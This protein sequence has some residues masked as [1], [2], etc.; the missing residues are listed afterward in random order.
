MR[1]QAMMKGLGFP[2]VMLALLCLLAGA[3]AAVGYRMFLYPHGRREGGTSLPGMYGALL[4]YAQEHNGWFP[5][6]TQDPYQAL[7]L[8]YPEYCPSGRELA[9][10]SGS[11]AKTA[12]ALSSGTPLGS[13]LSTWV[14]VSGLRSDDPGALAILWD[15]KPG[16]YQ[17]GR[18]NSFGGR[19]VLFVSGNISNVPAMDWDRFERKQ[20]ELRIGLQSKR[21]TLSDERLINPQ[22]D[23]Q[24]K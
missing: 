1:S 9:G 11:P 17:D 19:A 21:A 8:L 23:E 20:R 13:N 3:S 15:S 24:R 4:T 10:V 7:Q 18:R 5:G 22:R 2:K 12:Y 6:G 16:L 14:Y